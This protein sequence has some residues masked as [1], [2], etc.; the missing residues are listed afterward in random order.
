MPKLHASGRC[1]CGRDQ[2]VGER[3]E[4]AA[5]SSPSW[6]PSLEAHGFK[7]ESEAVEAHSPT[8]PASPPPRP[9]RAAR[10]GASAQRSLLAA[11]HGTARHSATHVSVYAPPRPLPPSSA[12]PAPCAPPRLPSV[13]SSIHVARASTD[14]ISLPAWNKGEGGTLACATQ[15]G[16]ATGQP[17][18]VLARL[19]PK[20]VLVKERKGKGRKELW[21][22]IGHP[23]WRGT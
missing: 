13:E 19:A 10:G 4:C 21:P 20:R 1:G 15:R 17:A 12:A 9:C 22:A 7:F 5:C 3:T 2:S 11:Q 18:C 8:R 23:R 6:P 14:P 16:R